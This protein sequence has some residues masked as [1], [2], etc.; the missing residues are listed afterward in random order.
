[1]KLTPR[2]QDYANFM[3][4][5]FDYRETAQWLGQAPVTVRVGISRLAHRLDLPG[6]VQ[7]AAQLARLEPGL[8]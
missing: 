5:G 7:L 6:Q 2:Q 4:A 8:G 3:L 1:M